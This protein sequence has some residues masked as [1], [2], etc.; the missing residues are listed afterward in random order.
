MI[1]DLSTPVVAFLDSA[2]A[3]QPTPGGGAT[4]ALVGA[5]AASMAEMALNYSVNKK[6]LEH[7]QSELK[8][9]LERAHKAR[10]MLQQLVVEDQ[11]AYEAMSGLQKLPAESP[12]RVAGWSDAVAEAVRVPQAVTA[13]CIALLELCDNMVNFVNPHLLSDLAVA[14]DLAMAGARCAVYNVR[15]NLSLITDEKARTHVEASINEMLMR[16]CKVIQGVSPRI[17]ERV[18][19]EKA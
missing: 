1:I 18:E 12:E 15:I 6:G 16:A 13:T 11:L 19:L 7:F 3:R 5:L 2:A 17:W 4:A 8:P 14:A 10:T 9:A